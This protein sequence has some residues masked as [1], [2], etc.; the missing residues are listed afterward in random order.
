MILCPSSP[1]VVWG[2]AAEEEEVSANLHGPEPG[3]P[4]IA[5][6][7]GAGERLWLL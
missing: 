6:G 4:V 5:Q 3:P 7:L 1:G 2:E